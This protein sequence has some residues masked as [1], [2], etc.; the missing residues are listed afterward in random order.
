MKFG[1]TSVADADKIKSV[2]R[3]IAEAREEGDGVLAVVSARGK[4]TD[5]LVA[6]AREISERP[7]PREMDM[8][9]STGE[10]IS[11]ALVAMALHDL[12]HGARSFTGS[13]AGILTDDSH[14]KAKILEIRAERLRDA[15]DDGH[16]VL[17]AGFQ[18]MSTDR[19]V[20]TL[21][22]GGSDTTA[23]ALAT[24]LDAEVC[25]I[26]TDV[27]GVFT[28]DPRIEPGAR[29]LSLVSHEEMLEMAATGSKVLALRSVEF[30]RRHDV[31]LHVRSSFQPEEGT[32][33]TKET[34]GM[35]KAIISGISHKSDE[36][37]VTI[38]G[39]EN[40]PGVA[41]QIFTALADRNLNVD[42]IIQ[43]VSD[44]RGADVSFTVPLDELVP[45]LNT[46]ESMRGDL[47]F[48][49][50]SSDDQIGKV[51]LI[52]AGMKSEPGV[53]AKMFR[54]LADEG[55]NLQMIDTSTIRITVVI[56]RRE[57][58]RAVRALH[59]AFD[60]A[61][62]AARREAAEAVYRADV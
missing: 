20:T 3:R 57:V 52:G 7:D 26:Y 58:E 45:A 2:A 55:I 62:E 34:P 46:L 56:D 39:V 32:W 12:G 28:A 8:L 54:V 61:S 18:G 24:A 50:L 31:P 21:G 60:L 33:I 48:R 5:G 16:I 23:V 6:L 43:N 36:A 19:N 38:A 47:G 59:D 1:G 30:A 40:R 11:C 42:T 22:R 13:Q 41:A 35:E 4:T 49:D 14:T 10:R 51:T 17:V 25:E 15:L 29:K 27:T 44:V 9:L 37:K 53:A